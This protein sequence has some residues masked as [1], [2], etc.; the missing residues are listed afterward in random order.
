MK[1][2]EEMSQAGFPVIKLLGLFQLPSLPSPA[3]LFSATEVVGKPLRRQFA[4][5]R[6]I[7]QVWPTPGCKVGVD[8]GNRKSCY[9]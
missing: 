2:T 1:L 6:K 3:F 5:L 4:G 8:P 7:R 9:K